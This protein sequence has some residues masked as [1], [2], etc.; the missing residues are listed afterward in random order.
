MVVILPR[1][2]GSCYCVD[3]SGIKIEILSNTH[4]TVVFKKLNEILIIVTQTVQKGRYSSNIGLYAFA[5]QHFEKT[6]PP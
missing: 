4:T 5:L 6:P 2:E 1:Y 3:L